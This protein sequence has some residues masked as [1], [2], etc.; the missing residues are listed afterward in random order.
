MGEKDLSNLVPGAEAAPRLARHGVMV[1]LTNLVAKNGDVAEVLRRRAIESRADL[2][3]MGAFKHSR[4]REWLLGGV[5][6]SM[7]KSSPVPLLLSH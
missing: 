7:L 5:T 4:L 3:V 6:Q 2:I 1:T